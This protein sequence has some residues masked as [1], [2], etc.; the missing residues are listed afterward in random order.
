[1]SK[2]LGNYIATPEVFGKYGS[3]ATRQ[4]AASGGAT[5]SDIP[6][7]WSDV[8]YGWRFLI[9]LWNAARFASL[10]LEDY[11]PREELEL[12]L[13]DRWLLSKLEMVTQRV[14]EALEN[15]QFNIATEEARAFTWH[16]FCDCYIEAMKHRLYKPET[17]GERSR[18]AAQ[19]TLYEAIY[20]TLQLLAPI[21]PH[22]TEEIYQAIYAKDKKRISI[23]VSPWPT[24]EK[25]KIDEEA[26]KYGDLIIAV[27]GEVRKNKA[28]R[29]MPLNSPIKKLTIYAGSK[30][31]SHILNQAAQDVA[32]TCKT[33]EISI[34]PEKGKGREVQGYPNI[35]FT[36]SY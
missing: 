27:I 5:G 32:G 4:W 7:R 17:F 31:S 18:K 30:K 12:E 15:C 21:S 26:E 24:L 34:L 10:H 36:A 20:R 33:L 22:V 14:T 19:Y 25:K 8:E 28:E 11:T 29:R 35:R 23:H 13:L 6:F 2:S 1:M 3:D 16:V 9:K